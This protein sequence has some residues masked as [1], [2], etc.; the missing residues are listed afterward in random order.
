MHEAN[1]VDMEDRGHSADAFCRRDGPEGRLLAPA[2][3]ETC[4]EPCNPRESPRGVE[5]EAKEEFDH[6]AALV[7]LL[8][9]GTLVICRSIILYPSNPKPE[10]RNP[11][12]APCTLILS[13]AAANALAPRADPGGVGLC[14]MGGF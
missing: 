8:K 2:P 10:T 6:A 14:R 7:E 12:P 3:Q 5:G 4:C 9:I 11:T 13:A 1:P